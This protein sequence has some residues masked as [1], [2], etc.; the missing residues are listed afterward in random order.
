MKLY[1]KVLLFF[2]FAL[3]EGFA[4]FFLFRYTLGDTADAP[5]LSAGYAHRD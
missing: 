4:L 5:P 3:R 1:V 2:L